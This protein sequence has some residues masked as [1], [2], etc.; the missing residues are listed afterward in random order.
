MHNQDIIDTADELMELYKKRIQ[1][2]DAQGTFY[3]QQMANVLH[4]KQE[5]IM[6]QLSEET[7]A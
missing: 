2:D 1:D 5:A 7:Q 6:R 3:Q 4:E